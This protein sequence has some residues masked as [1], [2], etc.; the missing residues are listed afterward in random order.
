MAISGF[1]PFALR[2]RDV[3]GQNFMAELN[4]LRW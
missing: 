1:N 4:I 3:L 2:I